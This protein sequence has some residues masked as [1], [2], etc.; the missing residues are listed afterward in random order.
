MGTNDR[1]V[2]HQVLIIAVGCQCLEH[3]FPHASMAPA[4]EALMDRLPLAIT[5]RQIAPMCARAQNPEA[6]V[7]KQPVIRASAPWIASLAGQQRRNLRP[8]NFAQFIP[9]GRHSKTSVVKHGI[10]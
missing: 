8:L 10:L 2:D 3:L 9:L 7:D 4:A 5:L 6:A 1:A